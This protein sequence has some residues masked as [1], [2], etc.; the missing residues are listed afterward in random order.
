M[1]DPFERMCFDDRDRHADT[2]RPGR[3]SPRNDST[4]PESGAIAA[5]DAA[6]P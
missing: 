5:P 2:Q 3:Q 1:A 4:G 6:A